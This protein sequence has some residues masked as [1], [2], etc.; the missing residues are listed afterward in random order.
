MTS[1]REK[2]LHEALRLFAHRGYERVSLRQLA[3]AVGL[4]PPTLYH[5]FPTKEA[6]LETLAHQIAERFEQATA[7]IVES[8]WTV[9]YKVEKFCEAHLSVLLRQPE[10][11]AIFLR[12]APQFLSESQQRAFMQRQRAYEER[13]ERILREGVEKNLFRDIEPRF[14]SVSLLA[15]M[16][17]TATWYQPGGPLSPREI[18]H[19][20]SDTFLNGLI[21]S[22]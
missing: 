22:W 14:M 3:S 6:V 1:Q 20:L 12:E 2:I 17:A 15:A 8:D 13:F 16:N 9:P 18:A 11:A 7:H 21:R 5:Y 10:Q 19:T 4:T